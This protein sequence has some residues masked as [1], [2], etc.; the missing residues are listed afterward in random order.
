MYV[1]K[2]N[3]GEVLKFFYVYFFT[4]LF[5]IFPLKYH[6]YELQ[7]CLI[8]FLQVLLLGLRSFIL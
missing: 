1:L 7:K 5:K 4:S 6:V 8:E 2:E 3:A